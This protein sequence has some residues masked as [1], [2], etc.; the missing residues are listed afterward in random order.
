[1]AMSSHGIKPFDRVAGFLGNHA[2]TVVAM[3][4]ATSL[5]AV[6][7]GVSADTGAALVVE[8]VCIE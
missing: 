5:G 6:W 3:L 4:A 1:M 7:T 8:K 2:D